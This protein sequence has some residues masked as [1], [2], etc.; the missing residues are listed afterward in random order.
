MSTL[1]CKRGDTWIFVAKWRES[2]GVA[3][4]LAGCTARQNVMREGSRTPVMELSS[5]DGDMVLAE[6]ADQEAG[7]LCNIYTRVEAGEMS[8]AP[9]CYEFDQE[10]TFPDGQV[11]STA[12]IKLQIIEDKTL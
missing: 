12:T 9:G 1:K 2:D 4:D 5:A 3:I 6:D 7:L 10:V 8:L 11:L